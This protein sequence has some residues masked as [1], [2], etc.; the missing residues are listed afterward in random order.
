MYNEKAGRKNVGDPGTSSETKVFEEGYDARFGLTMSIPVILCDLSIKLLWAIKH[1]F[2]NK[3]PL[4]ECIPNKWH[5]DLRIMLIFG[6]G[7]LCLMD[8]ADAAIRSGGNWVNFFLRLNIIAWFRLVSL[9][10]REIC[11][12]T[13]IS[14]PVQKQ[15]ETNAKVN[16]ALKLYLSELE[17]IDFEAFRKET[18]HYNRMITQIERVDNENEL[19]ILLKLE[20][21]LQ[22]ISL[23]YEG[24]FNDFMQDRN[25]KL[26]F[27]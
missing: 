25:G 8:G 17:Q 23:P 2:Y 26:V 3:R 19:N 1:Y 9:V 24:E 12:R 22:G 14:F 20:C 6:D 10:L 21:K 16:D 13:G 11:I 5:D 7:T 27:Q 18:E 15:L 4:S